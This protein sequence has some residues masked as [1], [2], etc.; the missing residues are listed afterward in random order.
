MS[1][2]A[3]YPDHG[4]PAWRR[5]LFTREM[6]IVVL[7]LLVVAVAMA[8]VQGFADTQTVYNILRNFLVNL[9]IALPMCLIMIT[10]DIDISVG[11][12]VGLTCSLLGVLYRAGVPFELAAVIVLGVGALGGL[13][14]GL[15][16][17]RIGL[18][19]LA[20][21]IGT[22]AL[23]R[24]LAV[25][26]LG[27]STVTKFPQAWTDLTKYA[28]GPTGIPVTI[29]VFL[30]LLVVFIYLLHYSSF[31]R[32]I[33]AIG[34][35][36]QA[37]AFSGVKV[38][39]TRTILFVLAGTVSALGGIYWTLLRGVARGDVGQGLELQ[40]IAAVVLGGVSVFGGVGA[41]YGVVAGVLL[42]SVL[43]N[44]LQLR[45][46]TADVINVITGVLLIGSVV[47]G[48]L[49]TWIQSHRA[50]PVLTGLAY[51]SEEAWAPMPPIGETPPDRPD[52]HPLPEPNERNEV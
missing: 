51:V 21:T 13:L 52:S 28:I 45:G 20:V 9:L 22:M 5:L 35:N 15:L 25:G 27:T 2:M 8:G 40:V 1:A 39:R 12:M 10:G 37:A 23:F 18:P 11:S 30:V 50:K 4:R 38:A 24:G 3:F 34:L 47:V 31:G 14:N 7:F 41:L 48:S 6:A 42:V 46:V 36:A 26:M 33:Y 43:S 19:A 44:A 16:V 17:T 32:G 29:V 49:L